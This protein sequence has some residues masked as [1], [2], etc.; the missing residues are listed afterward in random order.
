MLKHQTA[1]TVKQLQ[2]AL[3]NIGSFDE[4]TLTINDADGESHRSI[5]ISWE[6]ATALLV[7]QIWDMSNKTYKKVEVSIPPMHIF[8]GKQREGRKVTHLTI[9]I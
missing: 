8:A 7:D 2:N 6:Q 4:F 1:S 5:D 9:T 3:D